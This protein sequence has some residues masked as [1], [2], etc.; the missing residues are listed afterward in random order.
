MFDEFLVNVLYGGEVESGGV[1]AQGVPHHGEGVGDQV[2]D[3][4]A[5]VHMNIRSLAKVT[6]QNKMCVFTAE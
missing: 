1:V 5:R 3:P 2:K 6:L 4:P